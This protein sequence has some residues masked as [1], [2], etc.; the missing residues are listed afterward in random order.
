MTESLRERVRAGLLWSTV[1]SLVVRVGGML[2]F[3]VLARL[4]EPSA[5]GL[6]AAANVF[7]ALLVILAEQGLTEAVVQRAEIAD[8]E[9]NAVFWLNLIVAVLLVLVIWAAAPFISHQLGLP[10]LVWVLRVASAAI[11][12]SALSLGQ[13]ALAR[14]AFA[15]RRIAKI[16]TASTL[17]SGIIAVVLASA[18]MGVWSLVAQFVVAATLTTALL[19]RGQGL[20]LTTKVEFRLATPLIRYGSPRLA[21][22]IL[23]F[24]NTRFIDICLAATLGPAALGFYSVGVRIHQALMQTLSS[25]VLD[26]AHNAFSRLA[27]DRNR[28]ISAYYNSMLLTAALAVPIFGFVAATAEPITIALFGSR[29]AESADV[30]A[31][32]AILGAVQVLQCFNG[33]LYNAIGRPAIGLMLMPLKVM[34]TFLSLYITVGKPLNQVVGCF[35]LSQLPIT[36]LSYFLVRRLIGVSILILLQR[37]LPFIITSVV[38]SVGLHFLNVELSA[39]I[40]SAF[41][42]LL[43]L[44]PIG[45]LVY[46]SILVII[47]RSHLQTV[48]NLVR[49]RG[50]QQPEPRGSL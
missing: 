37:T 44:I 15:Y 24:L 1:Q 18:G 5:L 32:M 49:N 50:G 11:V 23:D 6:F 28:L 19:W 12:I 31:L 48:V 35:V 40:S 26:V 2:L 39:W 47:W 30:M 25:A 14:R 17:L 20:Q 16:A 4:L 38:M 46:F 21:T 3:V 45:A 13:L 9:V 29:W 10:E 43:L 27:A 8:R 34:L 36:P 42:R 33:T 7:L 22:N 41:L